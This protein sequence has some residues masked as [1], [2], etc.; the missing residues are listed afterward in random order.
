MKVF[1]FTSTVEKSPNK[2]G[3]HYA[4]LSQDM[5][6]NLRAYAGKNGSLPVVVT[7]GKTTYPTTVMSRGNQQWYVAIKSD[8][9][10]AENVHEGDTITLR[11]SPDFTR[12]K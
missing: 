12:I 3:W 1:E 10:E 8:V 4:G 6:N 2:G 5:L 7:L 11:I 9:R